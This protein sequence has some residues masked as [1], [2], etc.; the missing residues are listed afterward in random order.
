MVGDLLDKVDSILGRVSIHLVQ[1]SRK[2]KYH[3]VVVD[4][5]GIIPEGD[6]DWKPHGTHLLVLILIR[7]CSIQI[8]SMNTTS[9]SAGSFDD[10]PIM[11]SN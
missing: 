1:G 4:F 5:N 3:L 10:F 9:D 6:A 11:D 8:C 2:L 7:S